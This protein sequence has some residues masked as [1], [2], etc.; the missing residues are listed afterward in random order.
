LEF[1]HD[2]FMRQHRNR[3]ASDPPSILIARAIL[4]VGVHVSRPRP[5]RDELKAVFF[6]SAAI[7]E[8]SGTVI[9]QEA[10]LSLA[11]GRRRRNAH[12]YVGIVARIATRPRHRDL[13]SSRFAAVDRRVWRRVWWILHDPCLRALHHDLM[14]SS[15]TL[16][17]PC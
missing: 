11:L 9:F 13:V 2:H 5:D 12:Y 7:T 3:D 1:G 4:L 16:R 17:P 8:S 6:S 14:Y 10:V 15:R